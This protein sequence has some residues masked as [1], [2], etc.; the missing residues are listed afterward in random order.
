[1]NKTVLLVIIAIF[2]I[3]AGVFFMTTNSDQGTVEPG[4]ATQ[5]TENGQE[6]A[7]EE[8]PTNEVVIT[9]TDSGYAPD[10][11]TISSGTTVTFVNESSGFMWPASDIHPTHSILPEFDP[12]RPVEEG[13]TYSYTFTEEGAWSFHDHLMPRITGEI[14]VE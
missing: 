14:V 13:G 3:G 5:E 7:T 12:Q 9:Y 1:M 2:V 8:D 6:D 4:P 11:V 10:S